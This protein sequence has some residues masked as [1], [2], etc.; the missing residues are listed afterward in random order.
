MSGY[1]VP[2]GGS[3]ASPT[4][5]VDHD[6]LHL[7]PRYNYEAQQTGS[8]WVGRNF[9]GGKKVEFDLTP[10]IGG[11]FGKVNGIAPG[12]EA[13]ITYKKLEFYSANEYIFDT[14]TKSGNFFYTWT[15]LTYS[16]VRWFN[17]GYVM[18]RTRAYKTSLD[19]QRGVLIGFTRKKVTFA[20]QI[21]NFGWTDPTVVFSLGYS[22]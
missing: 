12:F 22:F 17:F 11:V 20:T 18:Q 7:E 14:D 4:L 6:W 10:M 8:L 16:P 3:Y 9:S 21:F 13:T 5:T 15:Q 19:V 2:D 1:L